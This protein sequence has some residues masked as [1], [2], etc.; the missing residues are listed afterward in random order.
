MNKSLKI[1][2]LSG[3]G[4]LNSNLSGASQ[5]YVH[6][7]ESMGTLDG[8]GLRY[9]IFLTGCPLQ[10]QYCHNPDTQD[11]KNGTLTQTE[12]ILQ[13]LERYKNFLIPSG[14][15]LTISGGEPLVQGEFITAL[16]EGAQK[17]GLHTTIDT[18]GSLPERFTPRLLESLDLALLDIKSIQPDLYQRVTHYDLAPTLESARLLAAAEKP[19]WLRFVVVPGLTDGDD[20]VRELAE[21]AATLGN[22][23]R[24]ELLP[25]HKMGE[26]KWKELGKRYQL[27]DT[28]PPTEASMAHIRSVFESMDLPVK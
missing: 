3:S 12:K 7:V 27:A 6:S 16:F 20:N 1:T 2:R 4:F 9:V 8:P 18:A 13:D 11:I 14:G 28:E 19:I 10:C 15:G 24:V 17:I 21:Y 25:F 26:H 5:G 22:I 23:E